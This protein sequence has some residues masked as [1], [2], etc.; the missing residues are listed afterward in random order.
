M[1]IHLI[2]LKDHRMGIGPQY[3]NSLMLPILA[4][5]SERLGWK[6][7]VSFTDITH[8]DETKECDVVALSLY[9]YLA[10]QG[11]ELA[12]KFRDQGK[13]VIIGG[14]HTKGCIEEV[15]NH[16][17]VIFDRCT[18]EVWAKVLKAIEK[19][20]I[21]P[22]THPGL[23]IPSPEMTDIPS[24]LQIK[25]FYGKAKIPLLLSSLGCPH[26]CDFCSDWNSTY[27]KRDVDD[28]VED[29]RNITA[30]FF[31]FCD[32][33]FGV[34]RKF[35]TDLL[36]RI[37]PLK[38]KYMMETSLVWLLDDDYLEL[39]RDSGCIGIQIGIES[40]TTTYKKNGIKHV[41]PMLEE[42]IE[43]IER[44]KKYIPGLQVNIV[45]GLDNDT[46]ETFSAVA[47]LYRRSKIDTLVPFVVTPLPGTPFFDRMR[48]EGRIF[49]TDW[50][51]FNCSKLTITLKH[52]TTSRFY[53]LFI[54]LHKKLHSPLLITRK[55]ISHLRQHRDLKMAT[56]LFVFLFIRFVNAYLYSIPDL[57]K[58]KARAEIKTQSF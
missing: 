29:I 23:F 40:L 34:N 37:I 32:P 45:L 58:A 33:N 20:E 57:W 44:I 12:R 19:K 3:L 16:A 46:E 43:N 39:L 42:T 38:K 41:K 26:D 56:M 28:V 30:S 13:L 52:F 17:D 54:D 1:R 51:Y 8:V 31:V 14:P 50:Q 5:W 47:E 7:E 6:A 35:T 36:R 11:Y 22:N 25:P 49:E 55:I 15:K 53:D 21:K 2:E 4:V 24:Y 10:P 48:T 9:S 18:E 27:R